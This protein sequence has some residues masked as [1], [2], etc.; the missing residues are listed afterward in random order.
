MAKVKKFA[1]YLH[2]LIFEA[3]KTD[4]EIIEMYQ[5]ILNLE[6][7]A[8][9]R[10]NLRFIRSNPEA[11]VK[12]QEVCEYDGTPLM[13]KSVEEDVAEHMYCPKCFRTYPMEV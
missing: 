1:M 9:L 11:I 2:R 5:P 4:K 3:K 6:E 13:H 10:K 8:S 7:M 12:M